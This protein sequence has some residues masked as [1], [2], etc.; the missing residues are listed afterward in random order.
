MYRE[1][2]NKELCSATTIL[3]NFTALC[4]HSNNLCC[5]YLTG[6]VYDWCR[7]YDDYT[8]VLNGLLRN[9]NTMSNVNIRR[10]CVVGWMPHAAPCGKQFCT[11]VTKQPATTTCLCYIIIGL[12]LSKYDGSMCF[13]GFNAAWPCYTIDIHLW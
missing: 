8:A 1:Y 11:M 9:A 7:Y 4:R 6:S 10:R 3:C 13:V 5:I 2:D 12:L